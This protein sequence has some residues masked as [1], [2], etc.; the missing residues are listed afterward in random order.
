[1]KKIRNH[2][3]AR[4]RKLQALGQHTKEIET[5]VQ[6]IGT[7]SSRTDLLALNASIES[8][9]AGEH[10]RGFAIVA[11]EVR[12]LA[13]QSAQ[14]V[15]DI[16]R[17][18]EM[19][20]LETH[21]SITVASG[22][23]DQMLVVIQRV[24]ETLDSLQDIC[25]AAGNSAEGLTEISSATNRQLQLTREII[26]ALERSTESSKRNRSRA[27]GANWTA[28]T[29]GQVGEQLEESLEVFRLSGAIKTSTPSPVHAT[30]LPDN[31]LP[32]NTPA[33]SL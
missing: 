2:A 14:A 12:A 25:D 18:I 27:E 16:T 32:V 11:E 23:H 31:E 30:E 20:Q 7:L 5:I 24:T 21:Q 29:L 33:L 19:I 9:R 13:E 28:R 6:T 15:L 17:R 26:I 3:A 4:E 10:G 1:M 22:E 8:V